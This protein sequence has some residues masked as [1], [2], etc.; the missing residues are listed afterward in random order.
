MKNKL[1]L[2]TFA[3]A[4]TLANGA[5]AQFT[6][7]SS[8]ASS[9][10]VPLAPGVITKSILSVGDDAIPGAGTFRMVGIPDGLG[11]FQTPT[12]VSNGTLTVFMTHET[13]PLDG[14]VR[15]HGSVGS[16]ISKFTVDATT[17]AVTAGSDL[18]TNVQVWNPGTSSYQLAN[19]TTQGNN[20]GGQINRFCSADLPAVSAFFNSGTGLGTQERI[21]LAGE[22]TRPPFSANHGRQFGVMATGADAGTAFELAR[23]GNGSWENYVF[24]PTARNLTIGIGFD[25]ADASTTKDGNSSELYMYVGT[26]TNSGND[27]ARAGLTN[28]NLYAFKLDAFGVSTTAITEESQ[29]FALGSASLTTQADFTLFNHGNVENDGPGITQQANDDANGVTSFRRIEDGV[30]SPGAANK[31][32][33]LTTDGFDSTPTSDST[34]ARS[35]LWEVT[36]TDI[37]NPTAG[38]DIKLLINGVTKT[39]L[40]N[41]EQTYG[42]QMMD[43]ITAVL[44]VDGVTRLLIQEDIGGNADSGKIWMYTPSTDEL[45]LVAEHDSAR[46]GDNGANP[47][48]PTDDTLPTGVF[49]NDEEASGIIPVWDTLGLGWFLMTD[50][51]HYLTGDT[52]TVQG[53]QFQAI[54]IPQAVPEPSTALALIGGAGMLLGLRRRRA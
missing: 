41:A 12:D 6:G 45:L 32:F 3:V 30:W 52:E 42:P 28:G 43:N 21:F 33:F 27:I 4:I 48:S 15:A 46:F 8:S 22:E 34:G 13:G 51:A 20:L 26:K 24:S 37:D 17:L 14:V 53:G 35:R 19:P 11:A 44:G 54:Y 25:D 49:N 50:Q 1:H 31:F 18:M 36:F 47:N 38:G 9:Y 2:L 5:H 7:P 29:P 39:P 10:V 23:L 40:A 16:F